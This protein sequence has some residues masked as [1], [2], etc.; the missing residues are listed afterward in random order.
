MR[1]LKHIN[2]LFQIFESVEVS[3]FINQDKLK[4][5]LLKDKDFA[6]GDV[7]Q[8]II[9]LAHDEWH[10]NKDWGYEDAC[11]WLQKTFGNLALFAMYLGKYNYQVCNGGH[12]QYFDNG[13]ASSESKGFS[14]NYEDIDKHEHF[15]ELFKQ[16]NLDNLLSSG[17]EAYNIISEFKLDLSDEVETCYSCGGDGEE[18]CRFCSGDGNIDCD[19]CGGEGEDEEGNKCENCDGNGNIE[20]EDCEGKGRFRCENCDGQGDVETGNKV[21]K[22]CMWERLD[23][24]W[25]KINDKFMDEFNNYLKSLTLDDEKIPDLIELADKT[26][27]YNL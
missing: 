8:A 18:E 24:R 23:D 3:E 4:Y 13:Y 16:L 22:T 21:P 26:Q 10:K 15:V 14:S 7:H 17:K 19:V 5:L 9:D 11:N 12:A 25:Y 27:K 6:E 20:C 1:H 2:E